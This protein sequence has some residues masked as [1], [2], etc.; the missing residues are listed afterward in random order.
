MSDICLKCVDKMGILLGML[1][2]Q[3]KDQRVKYMQTFADGK[4]Y[5]NHS[6]KQ[7]EYKENKSRLKLRLSRD[8]T[9]NKPGIATFL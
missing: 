8:C 5:C 7:N 3:T 1:G 9:S 4:H 2:K 6:N